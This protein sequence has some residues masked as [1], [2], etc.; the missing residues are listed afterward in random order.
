MKSNKCCENINV[1]DKSE[2]CRKKKYFSNYY[3][4]K[5]K[6]WRVKD[7]IDEFQR[8]TSFGGKYLTTKGFDEN[9]QLSSM[10]IIKGLNTS[11][12]SLLVKYNKYEE[13]LNYVVKEYIEHAL[14]SGKGD[15]TAFAKEH[16]YIG[17]YIFSSIIDIKLVKKIG[18]FKNDYYDGQYNDYLL[19]KHFS[20][21]MESIGKIPSV[22]EFIRTG[23]IL[24]S[25]YCDYYGIKGQL[26]DEVLKI[27]IDEKEELDMYFKQR[28]E[29]YSDKATLSLKKYKDETLIPLT[30]L[31][32][33]F[34]RVFD[35]YYKTYDTHPTRIMFNKE[36]IYNEITYRKRLRMRWSEVASFYGYEIKERNISEKVFL[37]LIKALTK[38]N[39]IRNKTWSWLIGVKGKHLYCDGYFPELNLVVE[40]DGK[41]HRTP[42]PNFGG[43]ERYL[44]DIENDKIK[45]TLVKGKNYNFLRVSTKE[46]WDNADYLKKKLKEVGMNFKN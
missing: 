13:L 37:E 46:N 35:Y 29:E 28:E 19:R 9:A 18:G 8:V 6:R 4:N 25:I 40:L 26:W 17:Q 5:V 34:K 32:H 21:V 41:H 39:Y 10:S 42:I 14:K 15:S 30:E 20:E 2:E 7:Y 1:E 44:R 23:K 16:P 12:K 31:E 24:P 33:E 45:E 43:Y 27:M 38:S 11:W 22:S 3:K 36:S